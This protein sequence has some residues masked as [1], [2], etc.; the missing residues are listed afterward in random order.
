MNF[1]GLEE[2]IENYVNVELTADLMFMLCCNFKFFLI[3]EKTPEEEPEN[4]ANELNLDSF[5]I[6]TEEILDLFIYKAETEGVKTDPILN[7]IV[8]LRA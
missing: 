3:N 7:E 6:I 5:F 8:D 4:K 1:T 2:L